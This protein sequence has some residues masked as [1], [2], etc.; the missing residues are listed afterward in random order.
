MQPIP[1]TC[2]TPGCTAEPFAYAPG[3]ED[4][5][6]GVCGAVEVCGEGE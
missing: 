2:V 4:T 5:R 6:V 3:T 1:T